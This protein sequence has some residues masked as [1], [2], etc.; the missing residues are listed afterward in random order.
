MA[1]LHLNKKFQVSYS[2]DLNKGKFL[3][4]TMNRGTHELVLGFLIGNRHAEF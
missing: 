3:L 2:Y 1:G 4:S